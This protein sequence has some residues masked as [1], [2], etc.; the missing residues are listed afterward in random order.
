MM[1]TKK[2]IAII[3]MRID[4]NRPIRSMSI[5]IEMAQKNNE[6]MQVWRVGAYHSIHYTSNEVFNKSRV[7]RTATKRTETRG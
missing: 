7:I 5:T 2:A 6:N 1:Q 4:L 3:N